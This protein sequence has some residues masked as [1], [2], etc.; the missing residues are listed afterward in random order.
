MSSIT[1]SPHSSS[2]KSAATS[3]TTYSGWKTYTWQAEGLSLK[4]PASWEIDS[5]TDQFGL[6]HLTITSPMTQTVTDTSGS[7]A[8]GVMQVMLDYSS[9]P[10]YPAS[11]IGGVDYVVK[12]SP[13]TIGGYKDVSLL[14]DGSTAADDVLELS[15][16]DQV[17]SVGETQLPNVDS[18]ISKD[19][20]GVTINTAAGL[21]Y[22]PPQGQG[23]FTGMPISTFEGLSD[24]S[25]A[26]NILLS[27]TY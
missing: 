18:F 12:V 13:Y 10:Q 14:E 1:G 9:T 22:Q 17:S 19:H 21:F 20:S 24:F 25:N 16:S 8:T 26:Q 15:L 27:L 4:Y 3:T 23:G 5:E 11:T 2:T 6:P 7:K